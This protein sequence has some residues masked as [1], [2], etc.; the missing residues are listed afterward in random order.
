MMSAEQYINNYNKN[1]LIYKLLEH[2]YK[3]KNITEI[4]FNEISRTNGFKTRF[5]GNGSGRMALMNNSNCWMKKYQNIYGPIIKYRNGRYLLTNE[6]ICI[7]EK[8]KI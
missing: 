2:L 1:L 4:K 3:E 5:I 7:L 8:T 6:W